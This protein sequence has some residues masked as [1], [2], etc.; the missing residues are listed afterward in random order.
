MFG[1]AAY[2][3]S[4]CALFS[5]QE[6]MWTAVG[7]QDNQKISGNFS[8]YSHYGNLDN[9]DNQIDMVML[10]LMDLSPK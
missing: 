1:V 6:G 2:H 8:K 9:Q 5:V 3:V 7:N 10:V 4:V